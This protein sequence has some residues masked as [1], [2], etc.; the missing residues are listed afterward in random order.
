MAQPHFDTIIGAAGPRGNINVILG[1]AIGLMKDL[2]VPIT[3]RAHLIESVGKS[4][5]YKE[6]CALI[7]EWFPIDHDQR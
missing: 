6:A 7:E 5:S 3:A 4:S 2:D 1:T